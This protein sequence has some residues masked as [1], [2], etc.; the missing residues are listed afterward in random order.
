[1]NALG[2][3]SGPA[4]AIYAAN[5]KWRPQAIAPTLQVFG[6]ILNAASLATLGGPE[7]DYRLATALPVGWL[8]G[9]WV[10]RRLPA[11]HLHRVVLA[12][13]AAGGAAA[14]MRAAVG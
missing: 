14:M 4:A 7:L 2:G 9:I 12:V 13:A 1:M 6:L 3:L 8:C 11:S 10:S 5:E